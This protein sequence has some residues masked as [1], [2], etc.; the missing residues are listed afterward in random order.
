MA[1][2]IVSIP[3]SIR[4]SPVALL[5][6]IAETPRV[7]RAQLSTDSRRRGNEDQ[8]KRESEAVEAA[9]R[10]RRRLEVLA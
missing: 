1:P 7:S 4:A 3:S 9:N 2:S 5:S 10:P 6:N 8:G